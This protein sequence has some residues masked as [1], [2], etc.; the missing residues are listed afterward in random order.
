MYSQVY[1][2]LKKDQ[3]DLVKNSQTYFIVPIELNLDEVKTNV[4]DIWTLNKI[5]FVSQ[6]NYE[7]DKEFYTKEGNSIIKLIKSDKLTGGRISYD[8][9]FS[10]LRIDFKFLMLYHQKKKKEN[11]KI[12]P[13]LVAEIYFTPS[14][15]YRQYTLSNM[16]EYNYEWR[17]KNPDKEIPDYNPINEPAS[18]NL[19]VG[20]IKNYFQTLNHKLV[21]GENFKRSDGVKNKL[22]LK[23]LNN[24]TLYAPDWILKQY[25]FTSFRL[26]K[27]VPSEELF[28]KYKHEYKVISNNELNSKILDGEDFYYFMY[29]QLNYHK[30]FSVI[31]SITG[32][33]I[34]LKEEKNY[35]VKDSDLKNISKLIN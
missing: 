12:R 14:I 22:K 30:I 2:N 16:T 13:L 19:N 9:N 26:K 34:Y 18:Y 25:S 24:Q 23:D 15:S 17:D 11:I 35:N 7:K 3:F 31:H 32:E 33:I 29:T 28:E 8:S 27:N 4:Q 6:D 20:Y 10:K 1:V 21:K 5:T